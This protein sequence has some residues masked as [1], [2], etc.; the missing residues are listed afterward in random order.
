M[1]NKKHFNLRK[2]AVILGV[3]AVVI[4]FVSSATA[5]PQVHGSITVEKLDEF[6]RVKTISSILS[7]EVNIENLIRLNQ[8]DRGSGALEI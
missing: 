7:E 4:L 8:K 6:E 3:L 1:N 2:K 5:V